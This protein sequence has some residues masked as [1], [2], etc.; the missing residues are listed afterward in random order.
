M[1]GGGTCI[2]LGGLLFVRF[3]CGV[4]VC[5]ACFFLVGFGIFSIFFFGKNCTIF[6]L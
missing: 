5:L 2:W 4:V 1:G 3:R 6:A